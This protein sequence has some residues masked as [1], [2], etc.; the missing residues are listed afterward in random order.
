M[1][2]LRDSRLNFSWQKNT[3][4]VTSWYSWRWW[5]LHFFHNSKCVT[6]APKMHNNERGRI[7][8]MFVFQTVFWQEAFFWKPQK[9]SGPKNVFFFALANK[10]IV[11]KQLF[12]HDPMGNMKTAA[13]LSGSFLL[14]TYFWLPLK[15]KSCPLT[16]FLGCHFWPPSHFWLWSTHP[17][18]GASSKH[19]V[20]VGKA[21]VTAFQ[22]CAKH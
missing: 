2:V 10:F 4:W 21:R 8:R 22:R 14:L 17:L 6:S 13:H 11:Q 12:F 5:N 19:A 16:Y 9:K 7:L 3:W 18:S 15:L 20:S 1:G